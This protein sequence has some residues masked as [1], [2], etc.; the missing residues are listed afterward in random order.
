MCVPMYF[1]R[2]RRELGAQ[3]DSQVL[4]SSAPSRNSSAV[5]MRCAYARNTV[6][7]RSWPLWLRRSCRL[8]RFAAHSC[9]QPRTPCLTNGPTLAGP[10]HTC[11]LAQ[12]TQS[13]KHWMDRAE[14]TPIFEVLRRS[15]GAARAR[16]REAMGAGSLS[17]A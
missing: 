17:S 1:G 10:A 6:H 8:R 4:E 9:S 3:A 11:P 13:R 7:V 12:L 14:A 16:S 5:C 15:D 2:A